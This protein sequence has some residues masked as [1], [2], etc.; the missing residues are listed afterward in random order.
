MSTFKIIAISLLL[1]LAFVGVLFFL[2]FEQRKINKNKNNHELNAVFSR[3]NQLVESNTSELVSCVFQEKFDCD[4]L[5]PEYIDNWD[6]IVIF[7][8]YTKLLYNIF[9][10]IRLYFSEFFTIP[11]EWKEIIIKNRNDLA[12]ER[13]KLVKNYKYGQIDNSEWISEQHH[14]IDTIISVDGY[15]DDTLNHLIDAAIKA[16]R[17]TPISSYKDDITDTFLLKFFDSELA[18]RTRELFIDS[19]PP[20]EACHYLMKEIIRV[21][22]Y[23]QVSNLIDDT[24]DEYKADTENKKDHD[25]F[26]G[27][28]YDYEEMCANIL[29]RAGWDAKATKKSGDQG[30]DVYAEKAG[31]SVVLQCKLTN[32]PVGN[33]AVQEIISGQ[34]FMTADFAAVVTPAKY[35]P[36][37]QD[38]ARAAKVLLLHHDDLSHLESLCKRSLS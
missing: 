26:N 18:E 23:I 17:K 12:A 13:Y 33:K 27:S 29:T 6:S 16:I 32:T 35:T 20:S 10:N 5:T 1:T 14:F 25:I 19:W 28:P 37:A 38:L 8:F 22:I 21:G 9:H 30:A 3:W 36:G 7:F 2:V 4:A 15:I 34:K 24:I 31:L 11:D